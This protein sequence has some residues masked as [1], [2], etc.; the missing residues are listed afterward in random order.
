LVF[1]MRPLSL[2]L[3]I[4]TVVSAVDR[5]NGSKLIP[6]RPEFHGSLF[7]SQSQSEV[8][9]SV[10]IPE[11]E[12]YPARGLIL[13]LAIPGIGQWYAGAKKKALLFA[14]LEITGLFAWYQLQKQG[15]DLQLDF[16]RFADD[17][18]DL[19]SWV[20]WAPYLYAQGEE[21]RDIII[22]GT[23]HLRI[24]L[25]EDIL[26]SDTLAS[27]LWGGDL[28]EV[29]VI[30]DLEFYENIGKYDQ[31]VS[32]WDD[33]FNESGGEAWELKY[34][35]VGDTTEV[36]VMTMHKKKYLNLRKESNTA[37]RM[38]SYAI[39]AIMLNHVISAI[40]AFWET[41]R[42]MV[43]SPNLDTS[44]R[45]LF[46]PYSRSGVGGISFSISW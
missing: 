36:I 37:Y 32:G 33:L 14:G 19:K 11:T 20:E 45:L 3:I 31:F 7:T 1:D 17:H 44:V 42:R 5:V 39:S 13:S 38:A 34:K 16:E 26:S 9:T 21:Y 25:G 30:R 35:D 23:H 43:G 4:V 10:T 6:Y 24:I 46:T 40:D 15:D 27:P 28:D 22:D 8:D 12:V 18:W 41:R 2:I 29:Q